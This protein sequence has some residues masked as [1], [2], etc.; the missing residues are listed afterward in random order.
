MNYIF[1][2]T[3]IILLGFFGFVLAS[4]IHN[5]KINNKKLVCPLKSDCNTVI[6][7]DYSK[8]LGIPVEVLGM[9]YY[10]FIALSYGLYNLG[11]F[12]VS[13][14][15]ALFWISLLATIFS[16]YLIFVQI[17][18]IKQLCVWCIGSACIC[19]LIFVFSYLNHF[20]F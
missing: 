14:V 8:I 12:T 7:S 19:L 11:F 1:S 4:Y 10:A 20:S 6:N 5:K 2:Q 3:I 15:D 13:F 9:I 18:K 16:F 17:V